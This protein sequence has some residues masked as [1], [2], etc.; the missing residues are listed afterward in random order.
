MAEPTRFE[1]LVA[2]AKKRITEI[3]PQ[4]AAA[5][6]KSS[7][8]VI[9]DVRER[10]MGRVAYSRRCPH[11]PRHG[12]A[13]SRRKI[14]RSQHHDH[15]SLRRRRTIRARGRKFAKDGL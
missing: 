6:T 7:D 4:E 2:D 10:R 1:K 15:L 12:R 9:V 3:S 11:E 8:A 5:K 13:R 14:S